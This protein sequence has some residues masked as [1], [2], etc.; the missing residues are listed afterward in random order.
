MNW[1]D[2]LILGGL[3]VGGYLLAQSFAPKAPNVTIIGGSA[4]A[5]PN[6]PT[7]GGSTGKN[8]AAEAEARKERS[9]VQSLSGRSSTILTGFEEEEKFT[10]LFGIG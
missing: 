1:T 6:I 3:A 4:A 5:P 10:N 7:P 2:Y 8:A 9:R